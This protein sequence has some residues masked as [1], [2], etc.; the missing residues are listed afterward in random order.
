VV[1]I[2]YDF[3][4]R[5]I[6][7]PVG[8]GQ[9]CLTDRVPVHNDGMVE[10]DWR[11]VVERLMTSLKGPATEQ[12]KP[13]QCMGLASDREWPERVVAV[14]LR[15]QLAKPLGFGP[16]ALPCQGLVE[17]CQNLARPSC[18]AALRSCTSSR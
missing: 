9:T 5:D 6:E 16:T 12:V 1:S 8:F 14:H 10:A 13:A 17:L 15:R 3:W 2:Q 7:L 18:L 4:F 11:V